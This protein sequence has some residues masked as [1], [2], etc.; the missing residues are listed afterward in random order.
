MPGE[1]NDVQLSVQCR[2]G[3]ISERRCTD[4]FCCIIYLLLVASIIFLGVFASN[5]VK[6]SQHEIELKLETND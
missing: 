1:A 4:V 2:D 6:M 3:P 5:A